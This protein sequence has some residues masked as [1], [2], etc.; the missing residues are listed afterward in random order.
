MK[1]WLKYALLGLTMLVLV[2]CQSAEETTTRLEYEEE[3]LVMEIILIAEGDKVIEQTSRNE[4]TY[5][6]F[7]ASNAEEAEEMLSEFLGGYDSTEGV[8][9]RIDY[10]GDYLIEEVTVNYETVDIDEMKELAGTMFEG[11]P[12]A[13]IS[14]KMTIDMLEDEGFELAD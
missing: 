11:D 9:H 2:A 8:T 4:M 3:G 5:E 10:R 14:L 6:T 13:G 12:S 1:K 7:G